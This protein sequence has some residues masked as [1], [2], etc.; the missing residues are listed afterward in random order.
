MANHLRRAV[1]GIATVLLVTSGC[2]DATPSTKEDA[3][4]GSDEAGIREG[5]GS[6]SAGVVEPGSPGASAPDALLEDEAPGGSA[7]SGSAGGGAN[8]G[9][10]PKSPGCPYVSE[11]AEEVSWQD[12]LA[13]WPH[14]PVLA[15][16]GPMDFGQ[17][18]EM[19]IVGGDHQGRQCKPGKELCY[20][21]ALYQ[22]PG[23]SL[24]QTDMQG[25]LEAGGMVVWTTWFQ[26]GSPAAPT[27]AEDDDDL[28]TVRGRPTV[29]VESKNDNFRLMAYYEPH[30]Q[31]GVVATTFY[32][33]IS[34]RSREAAVDW[35]NQ[36]IEKR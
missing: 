35:A 13:W 6:P 29:V 11:H 14:R 3:Q 28:I 25:V 15:D 10:V 32:S 30:G 2:S 26:P 1:I 33:A 20:I 24:R 12:A 22:P 34:R 16:E 36:L 5:S 17:A 7:G 4:S 31:G 18:S 19:V 27:Y 9:C 8:A 21:A 23:V